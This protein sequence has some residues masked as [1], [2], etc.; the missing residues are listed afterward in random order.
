MSTSTRIIKNTGFLYIRMLLTLVVS[1]WTTRI[2]LNALGVDNFG[3]YNVVG[4]AI[5]LLGFLNATMASASQRFLSYAEG[6]GNVEQQ[7]VVFNS[8]VT[9]HVIIGA[10]LG[11]VLVIGYIFFFNG[12]LNIPEDKIFSAKIVYACMGISAVLTVLSVPFDATINAHEDMKYYA[13][14]GIIDVILKLI[15]A[16]SI[17]YTRHD[18]LIIYGGLMALVPF[19]SLGLMWLY[20]KKYKECVI[21]PGRYKDNKV[22]K[23]M[24]HFAGWNFLNIFSGMVT[25]YG[26]NIVINHFYGV[27]LNA[28]QGIANQVTGVLSNLSANALKALNPAI[29]KSESQDQHDRMIYISLLGCRVSFI[30]FGAI[31]LP[32]ILNMDQILIGWLKIVP[33]WAVIFCQ[34][35][36]LRILIEQL[37][38]G[39]VTSIM[40]NGNIRNYN[41]WKSLTNFIPLIVTPILFIFN[42]EPY[43]MYI[44]WIIAWSC[45]GGCIVVYFCYLLN[46]M[47]LHEYLKDVLLPTVSIWGTAYILGSIL[48]CFS[49]SLLTQFIYSVII[50]LLFIY[51]S[52]IFV[53]QKKERH[54]LLKVMGL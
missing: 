26:L 8:C 15:I 46:G 35:S 31:A 45:F 38:F 49:S 13:M 53:L 41:I 5:S 30:I 24:T 7:K 3:I 4:G 6:K 50:V 36:L 1:L 27:I 23:E 11:V 32:V 21:S 28:S 48:I 14:I 39:L 40:A 20:C 10:F 19:I 54:E 47:S 37:S 22:I 29:V 12:I 18:K 44:I 42:L 43:W 33:Q 2:I 25:Q 17:L 9:L 52:W 16:F 34:L 51:L